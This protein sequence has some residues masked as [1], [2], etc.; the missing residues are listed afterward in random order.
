[1]T[2]LLNSGFGI[3]LLVESMAIFM[4]VIIYKLK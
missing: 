3:C 2:K 4:A 1:M